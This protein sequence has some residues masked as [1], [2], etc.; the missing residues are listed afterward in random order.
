M[1][2]RLQPQHTLI[3]ATE[4]GLRRAVV[5]QA[6][7]HVLDMLF[8][9]RCGRDGKRVGLERNVRVERRLF[10]LE[11]VVVER[12]DVRQRRVVRRVSERSYPSE[13]SA[14]NADED[15]VNS[16]SSAAALLRLCFRGWLVN[17]RLG[18]DVGQR[19]SAHAEVADVEQFVLRHRPPSIR[20]SRGAGATGVPCRSGSSF[21]GGP[22]ARSLPSLDFST[23]KPVSTAGI[24][25]GSVGR[26]ESTGC[27]VP[28]TAG[29]LSGVAGWARRSDAT[30]LASPAR[31]S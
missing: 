31:S 5:Q 11:G 24:P 19:H 28:G 27:A 3:L 12:A 30:R 9:L 13:L 22:T 25:M 4:R 18:P 8:E 23:W 10:F 7:R 21:S 6:E 14:T 16:S 26:A 29:V 17:G 1:L 15:S 20:A 2:E